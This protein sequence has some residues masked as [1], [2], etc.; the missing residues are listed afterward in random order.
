MEAHSPLAFFSSLHGCWGKTC[1]VVGV[2]G[3]S[4]T[5]ISIDL[6]VWATPSRDVWIQAWVALRALILS[7]RREASGMFSA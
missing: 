6:S 5:Q 1:L 7:G 4:S 2:F 3:G